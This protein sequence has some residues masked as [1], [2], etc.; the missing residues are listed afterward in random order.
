M[1]GCTGDLEG[2]GGGVVR[3][4]DTGAEGGEFEWFLDDD[5]FE[6]FSK[7]QSP[8]RREDFSPYR[9]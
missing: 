9:L 3:G 7:I 5:S 8:L 2:R 6:R 4:E 1:K